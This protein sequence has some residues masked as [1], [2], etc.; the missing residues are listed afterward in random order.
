MYLRAVSTS[1]GEILKTVYVSKTILSQAVDIGLFR[2]VNFQRL[3]EVETGFTKNEPTQLAI[4]ESIEK[5]VESLI[6]EGI[7]SNLWS[8]ENKAEEEVVVKNYL[9]EKEI[10]ASTAL[11]ERRFFKDNYKHSISGSL[12]VAFIDG[13]YSSSSVDISGKIGYRYN[14]TPHFSTHL[15][16]AILRLRSSSSISNFVLGNDLNIEYKFL[17]H[18]KFS[19][20][21]YAGPGIIISTKD[22]NTTSFKTQFGVGFEYHTSEQLS[23]FI[24]GDYNFTFTD[25][26]DYIEQGTKDDHYATFGIGLNFHF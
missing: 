14:F 26:L 10:D 9:E 4:Q 8:S 23:I 5:A 21:V 1:T 18:D 24:N 19:P 12:G 2:Y 20:Y 22:T 13:D 6:I 11:Y 17:P 3:L 7:I 16:I 25:E 15:E